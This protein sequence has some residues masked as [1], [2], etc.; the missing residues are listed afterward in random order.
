MLPEKHLYFYLF[1]FLF[2]FLLTTYAQ[3]GFF[4]KFSWQKCLYLKLCPQKKYVHLESLYLSLPHYKRS[5]HGRNSVRLSRSPE[6]R[7]QL[8]P[9]LDGHGGHGGYWQGTTLKQRL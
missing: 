6:I 8:P 5:P 9:A 2:A 4:C 1:A 3:I 7:E